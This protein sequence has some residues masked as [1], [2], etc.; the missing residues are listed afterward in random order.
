MSSP[1]ADH[2]PT[3][4][5][6]RGESIDTHDI[7]DRAAA[8][9]HE[10]V[11]ALVSGG[12]DSLTTLHVTNHQHPIELDGVVHIDTGTGVPETREFVED[13]CQDLGLDF[14][15]IGSEYRQPNEE[16]RSLIKRYGFPGPAVHRW[17]YLNLKGKPLQ[18]FVNEQQGEVA[19]V[20]GVR[21][22]ESRNRM[23]NI[24]PTGIQYKDGATW[25]SPL[26]AWSDQDVTQ[27]RRTEALPTNPVVEALHM[28]GE[29]LCLDSDVLVSTEHG[30]REIEHVSEG[31][32]VHS[33]QDGEVELT[34]VVKKHVQSPAEMVEIKPYY[35]PELTATDN[36]PIYARSYA[37]SYDSDYNY[38]KDIGNPEWVDAGEIVG[39]T[40]KSAE[41]TPINKERFY[42]GVPFRTGES[43]VDLSEAQLRFIGYF[44]A[45]GAFL[46]RPGRDADSHG[47]M[48]TLSRNSGKLAKNIQESF[49]NSFPELTMRIVETEDPRDGNEYLCLRTGHT[50]VSAFLERWVNGRYS[51]G[52]ELNDRLLTA[53]LEQQQ[54]LLDAM[55]MGDGSEYEVERD[56]GAEG[57]R[58]YS[59]SSKRLALQVQEILLR[60]GEV[61]GINRSSNDSYLVRKS[62]SNTRYGFIEGNILWCLV[63]DVNEIGPRT[64]F[65]LTVRDEPNFLTESG[66]VHNCG[67]YAD[68]RELEMLKIFYPDTARFIEC[69]EMDV[70]QNVE[71]GEISEEFALWG[72]G[73]LS[74]GE[75]AA[76]LDGN[77]STLPLCTDC[78]DRY[79]QDPYSLEGNAMSYS[80]A[81][82][83]EPDFQL[84]R[85]EFY[86]VPCQERV[87]DGRAHRKAVHPFADEAAAEEWDIR[88]I[89]TLES[90]RRDAII[91]EPTPTSGANPQCPVGHDWQ[92]AAGGVH[93]CATCGAFNLSKHHTQPV[94]ATGAD[95]ETEGCSGS[96]GDCTAHHDDDGAVTLTSFA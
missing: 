67:A 44:V 94:D 65:N 21:Q 62:D 59:T 76:R 50:E 39:K 14:I 17:Q 15:K 29:C 78:E 82:L 18:R 95:A 3:T 9:N 10:H 70:L 16:Y 6:P 84:N 12:H 55:W 40:R 13:R 88:A 27:Y 64:R 7:L 66:L 57:V 8:Q 25:I 28:S 41:V 74:Q 30:W 38:Q 42:I 1:P 36:H 45:E 31:D 75:M 60:L 46:W 26:L 80:E 79:S 90:N 71:R 56:Y 61:Y 2:P 19:L 52:L 54:A 11:Y 23:E 24:E 87:S 34:E 33:L 96:C 58:A 37:F 69:L 43:I 22:T 73:S 89:D 68:R 51:P 77:Q 81:T 20:S 92:P 91:T 5:G 93:Q 32:F 85:S 35:R 63:Q 48:F 53:S 49:N 47:V 72:N 4:W 86:C 83:R